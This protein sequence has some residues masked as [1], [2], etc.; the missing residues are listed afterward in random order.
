MTDLD[1]RIGELLD[2]RTP[3]Q[4]VTRDWNA[5]LL[6][7]GMPA[8]APRRRRRP[9]PGWLLLAA[10]LVIPAGLAVAKAGQGIVHYL[11]GPATP[12]ERAL[13][14]PLNPTFA[15]ASGIRGDVARARRLVSITVGGHR[16]VFVMVPLTRHASGGCFYEIVDRRT[17]EEKDCGFDPQDRH[18]RR[19]PPKWWGRERPSAPNRSRSSS[20]GSG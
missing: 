5:V 1:P 15:G 17:A 20:V 8:R 2:A 4:A 16:Y 9:S 13:V 12:A 3:Q 19:S 14:R 18:P 6:R 11:S 7:A 10:A